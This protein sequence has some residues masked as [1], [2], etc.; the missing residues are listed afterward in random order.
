M[1]S[2][3]QL[4]LE[5]ELIVEWLQAKLRPATEACPMSREEEARRVLNDR[6]D[7][8]TTMP[9]STIVEFI[10][11]TVERQQSVTVGMRVTG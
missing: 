1:H 7:C 10:P 5:R 8:V 6:L 9:I 11:H 2:C 4:L 3:S